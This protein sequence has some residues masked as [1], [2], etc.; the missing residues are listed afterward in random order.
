LKVQKTQYLNRE[1][2]WK[3]YF[4]KSLGALSAKFEPR[5]LSQT[6]ILTAFVIPTEAPWISRAAYG[7]LGA[8][9]IPQE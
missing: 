2:L 1:H 8:T 9:P 5:H 4:P 7:L 6:G 3:K